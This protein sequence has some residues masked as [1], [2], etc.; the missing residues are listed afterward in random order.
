M[1]SPDEYKKAY[2]REREARKLAERLLNEKS[3]EA[4]DQLQEIRSQNHK[5]ETQQ[6]ELVESYQQLQEAHKNIQNTQSQLIQSGKMASLGQIAAGVAHEINNPISFVFSNMQVL[7]DYLS[8]LI[9]TLGDN[10]SLHDLL[11]S[12]SNADIQQQ[13]AKI[14]AF[15]EQKDLDFIVSDI[16]AMLEESTIGLLRV[17]DI[18]ANLKT[19]AHSGSDEKDAINLNDC[20]DTTLKVTWNELKYAINVVRDYGELPD[21]VCSAGQL[22]QVFMNLIL[23]ARD[24]CSDQGTLT[25]KTYFD[26]PWAVMEFSDN[27][28]G[29]PDEVR[30]HIF[31]PFYTTKPVGKGTGLGLSVS[32]GIIEN[33]QGLLEV[34]SEENKGTTFRVKLPI[35]Q[36]D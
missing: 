32:Y 21:I 8:V 18:V 14:K 10:Q 30:N 29:I 22:G 34:E 11:E 26:T 36:M 19:F 16:E 33:H 23:N 25:I 7:A 35:T 28:S 24:A 2:E 31:E 17:K 20:I 27:G 13:L 15:T 9:Q 6:A 1:L 5:L 4:Y 12:N 3:R